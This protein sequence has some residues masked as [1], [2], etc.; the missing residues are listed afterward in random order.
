MD[1]IGTP[2]PARSPFLFSLRHTPDSRRAFL[3]R[4]F[5]DADDGET[6]FHFAVLRGA[7][8]R[9]FYYTCKQTEAM[10]NSTFSYLVNP[11]TFMVD[12]KNAY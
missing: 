7:P 12:V 5:L 11:L 10:M 2:S 8:A 6:R 3:L 1:Q 9:L 4:F